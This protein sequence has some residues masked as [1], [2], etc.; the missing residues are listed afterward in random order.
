M[1]GTVSAYVVV[2]T[3]GKTRQSHVEQ[4]AR[5]FAGSR[6]RLIGVVLLGTR[7]RRGYDPATDL[8][9]AA[10]LEPGSAVK[11]AQVEEGEQSLLE[12]FGESL[13]A[14]GGDDADRR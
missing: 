11:P 2:A 1:A 13:A 9:M 3:V 10:P 5:Q 4:L 8:G 14:M 6:S 7:A 12:R